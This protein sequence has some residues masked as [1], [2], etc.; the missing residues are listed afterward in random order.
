MICR[1]TLCGLLRA[2]AALTKLFRTSKTQNLSS[3]A[4]LT[5][6]P[7]HGHPGAPGYIKP[8]QLFKQ[9]LYLCLGSTTSFVEETSTAAQNLI[10]H[11]KEK[12]LTGLPL[13]RLAAG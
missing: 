6:R 1:V 9:I 10:R 7:P 3:V 13:L 5:A 12:L 8:A 11:W 4:A 2:W